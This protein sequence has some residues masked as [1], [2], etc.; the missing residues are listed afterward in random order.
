MNLKDLNKEEIK[1]LDQISDNIRK[2]V[3]VSMSEGLMAIDYQTAIK[4]RKRWWQ[5]WKKDEE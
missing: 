3:P 4:Q 2:G 1:Y 5:F